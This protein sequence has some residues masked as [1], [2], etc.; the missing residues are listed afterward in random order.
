MVF[1]KE[2][3]R[4]SADFP[5]EEKFGLTSQI[6][7]AAVSIP[8][9]I[10][11]GAGRSSDIEFA[12]FIDFSTGSLYEVET[13][14]LLANGFSYMSEVDKLL[15]SKEVEEL[16]KMIRAFKLRLKTKNKP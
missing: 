16:G 15:I 10:A 13:Q 3:Y 7:R 9:N 1:V 12:R 14:C 2:I 11:E 8:S 4:I 6:R 5:V